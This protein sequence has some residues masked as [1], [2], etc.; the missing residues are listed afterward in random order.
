MAECA[1]YYVGVDIGGTSVKLGLFDEEGALLGKKSIP[2][3]SLAHA[4]G[5]AAVADGIG[6]LMLWL[7]FASPCFLCGASVWPCLAPCRPAA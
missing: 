1:G 4:D 5:H 3:P 7:P 6:S 2:T